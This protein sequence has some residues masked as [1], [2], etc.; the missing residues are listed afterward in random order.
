[1]LLNNVTSAYTRRLIIV[2]H[3]KR[4]SQLAGLRGGALS[5]TLKSIGM[6]SLTWTSLV[7]VSACSE[8]IEPDRDLLA[9]TSGNVSG[10][11]SGNASG[12][13]TSGQTAGSPMSGSL[14]SGA[15]TTGSGNAQCSTI[16]PCPQDDNPCTKHSCDLSN[17]ACVSENV[18]VDEDGDGFFAET[19]GNYTCGGDDCD[20][21]KNYVYPGAD[22]FCQDTDYNCDG[23]PDF[24]PNCI[25]NKCGNAG[26]QAREITLTMNEGTGFY[27]ASVQGD[28]SHYESNVT[29]CFS[30]LSLRHDAVYSFEAPVQGK[31]LV[32]KLRGGANSNWSV[33][34]DCTTLTGCTQAEVTATNFV[35]I[36]DGL[37]YLHIEPTNRSNNNK[38][39]NLR[40]ELQPL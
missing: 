8:V 19:I 18:P 17:F 4:K 14:V 36:T 29:D 10:S 22:A 7:L 24:G 20:D 9:A 30:L 28:F 16:R 25:G 27:G 37:F 33:S 12:S 39:F 6:A 5:T 40:I 35:T 11:T 32:Y 26:E 13:G 21:E 34:A 1:M 38:T 23:Q 31:L 2:A 3:C 15:G